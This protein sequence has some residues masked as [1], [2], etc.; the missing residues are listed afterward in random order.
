[1]KNVNELAATTTTNP[2]SRV[3]REPG[4]P[5]EPGGPKRS[6]V[7]QQPDGAEVAETPHDVT[8]LCHPSGASSDRPRHGNRC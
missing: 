4:E 7:S 5:G 1:M 6:E 2:P 8:S 3:T